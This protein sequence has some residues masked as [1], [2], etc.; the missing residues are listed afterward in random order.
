M[1]VLLTCILPPLL[2][3]FLGFPLDLITA[4][5]PTQSDSILNL[6]IH[7][8]AFNPCSPSAAS[9]DIPSV[10][11]TITQANSDMFVMSA[12]ILESQNDKLDSKYVQQN[13]MDV[14]IQSSVEKILS[15]DDGS[16]F[17]SQHKIQ[18][19]TGLTIF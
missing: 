18:K 4:P 5:F 9:A 6:T 7:V 2:S 15:S 8:V 14:F 12:T 1:Y 19:K 17:S 16:R 10:S 3:T 13:K 11:Q